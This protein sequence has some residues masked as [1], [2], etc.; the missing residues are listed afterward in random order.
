MSATVNDGVWDWTRLKDESPVVK[1][2]AWAHL[3]QTPW[4]ARM[5]PLQH[6]VE[7]LMAGVAGWAPEGGSRGPSNMAR[8]FHE[9]LGSLSGPRTTRSTWTPYY[10]DSLWPRTQRSP[11]ST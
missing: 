6:T 11:P 4:M 8:A 9:A 5:V 1:A 3:V 7:V 2:R 10:M